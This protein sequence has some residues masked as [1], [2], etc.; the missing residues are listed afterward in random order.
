MGQGCCL[1]AKEK[2]GVTDCQTCSLEVRKKVINCIVL[3]KL[4]GKG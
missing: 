1:E 4:L 2:Y 3:R